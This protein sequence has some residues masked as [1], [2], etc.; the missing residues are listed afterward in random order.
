MRNGIRKFRQRFGMSQQQVAERLET[1]AGQ[2]SRWE[3]GV[4]A[5]TVSLVKDLA[6][7]FDCGAGDI[8]GREIPVDEWARGKFAIGADS[9]RTLFGTLEIVTRSGRYEYPISR[10]AHESLLLQL[11]G[12]DVVRDREKSRPWLESWTLDNRALHINPSHIRMLKLIDDDA[13]EAPPYAH[14][15]VFRTL[16]ELEIEGMEHLGPVLRAEV[17]DWVKVRGSSEAAVRETD[18][19]H[20][21]YADGADDWSLMANEWDALGLFGLEANSFHIP[22]NS[23]VRIQTD[24]VVFL[25]IETTAIVEVPSDNFHRLTAPD[26]E[27]PTQHLRLV[28]DE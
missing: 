2:V 19:V 21:I 1:D 11:D 15:E 7:L 26:Y 3:R 5:L 10:K 28:G 18:Y 27:G 9:D 23:F 22:S 4:D 25:N 13:V 20:V 8:M 14:P 17:E 24:P 12:M 6:V 16:R